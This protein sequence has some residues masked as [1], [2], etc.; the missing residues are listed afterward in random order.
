[1]HMIQSY[2]FYMNF[3]NIYVQI[4]ISAITKAMSYDRTPNFAVRN[5]L[6]AEIKKQCA[7]LTLCSEL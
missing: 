5:K 3:V 1:M 7:P 4:I 2:T 6:S